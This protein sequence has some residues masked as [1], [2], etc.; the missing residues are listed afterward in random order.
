LSG[1]IRNLI[2][3]VLGLTFLVFRARWFVE[4]AVVL[5]K[6]MG[7]SELVI[8][9]TIVALGTS[10]PEVA[11]SVV[12]AIKGERDIAVAIACLPIFFTGSVITRA[13]GV[14]F[15]AYYCAYTVALLLTALGNG[16]SPT[17][18]FFLLW[19]ALPLTFL[20]LAAAVWW[21]WKI[22]RKQRSAAQEL[23]QAS[24]VETPPIE[25]S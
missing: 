17:F 19:F 25:E 18:N 13:N 21:E 2:F 12:A 4:S 14:L 16:W 1:L 6:L 20:G 10:L 7:L 3:L 11:T 24:A 22:L 5:A 8:G 23:E 15:F 9:L